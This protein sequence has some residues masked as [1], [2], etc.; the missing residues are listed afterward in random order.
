MADNA[1]S[2]GDPRDHT[3][4]HLAHRLVRRWGTKFI[5][6]D[7][8]GADFTG[9]DASRC[10]VRRATVTDVQWDPDIPPPLDLP[11]TSSAPS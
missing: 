4:R 10:D 11:T 2:E 3:L 7:L 6:A 5:E 8:T 1:P 9:A